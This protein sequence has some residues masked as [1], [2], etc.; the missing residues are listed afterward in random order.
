ME[1]TEPT[2]SLMRIA[3]YVDTHEKREELRVWFMERKE[4]VLSMLSAEEERVA[5][6]QGRGGR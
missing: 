3:Q 6:E 5:R 4:E 1:S 2:K